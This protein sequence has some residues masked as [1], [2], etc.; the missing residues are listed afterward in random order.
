MYA[1]N[2]KQTKLLRLIAGH[3]V[4]LKSVFSCFYF[5]SVHM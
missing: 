3:V 5:G 1:S 2:N 4:L